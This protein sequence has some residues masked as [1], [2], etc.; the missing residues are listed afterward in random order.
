MPAAEMVLDQ[1]RA[2]IPQRLS[3]DIEVDEIMETLPHRRPGVRAAGLGTS[4]N[5]DSHCLQSD[6][7][8]SRLRAL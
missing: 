8:I 2:V 6:R 1:K 4:K 3:L 5:A 7:V